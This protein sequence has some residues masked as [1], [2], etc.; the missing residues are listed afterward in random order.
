MESWGGKQGM[1]QLKDKNNTFGGRRRVKPPSAG[2]GEAPRLFGPVPEK[3]ES[4]CH[5]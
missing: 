1:G 4:A 2:S 5:F 3:P